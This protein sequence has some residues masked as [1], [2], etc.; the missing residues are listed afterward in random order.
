M[1]PRAIADDVRA[2]TS[3]G[4]FAVHIHPRDASGRETLDAAAIAAFLD[5]PG[6]IGVTTGA[7]IEP[8]PRKRC[9]LIERWT[10]LPEFASVNFDEAGAIEVAE[11][12]IRRGVSVEAGLSTPGAAK[13]FMSSSIQVI[14]LLFEPQEQNVAD[15][16]AN[17]NAI[18]EIV[19]LRQECRLLHGVDATAWPLVAEAARRNWDTRIG[20]EDTL[21]LPNGSPAESNAQLV[22]AAL[23]VIRA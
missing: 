4:A 23:E 5:A 16:I 1:T 8:D 15:A 7:W 10:R 14:R 3:A 18:A 9:A 13:I 12:L 6:P 17:V 20:F 11:L 19:S 22:E 2:V 21:H